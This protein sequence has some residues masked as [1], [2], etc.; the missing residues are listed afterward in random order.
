[1]RSSLRGAVTHAVL[2]T[3]TFRL[4]ADGSM[5]EFDGPVAYGAAS[6]LEPL[7]DAQPR[8]DGWLRW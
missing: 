2:P 4:S 8:P 6:R 3:P 5:L 7:L 1:M